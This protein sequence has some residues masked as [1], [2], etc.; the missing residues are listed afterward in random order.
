[1]GDMVK[2]SVD[3]DFN[4]EYDLQDKNG[5]AHVAVCVHN[6]VWVFV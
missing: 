4:R 1:M 2:I 5:G 3:C 6:K